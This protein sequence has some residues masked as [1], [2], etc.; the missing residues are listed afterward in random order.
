M[1]SILLILSTILTPISTNHSAPSGP[2]TINWPS[3][4]GSNACGIAE[5]VRTP[6]AWNV[7][8]K[9][10]VLWKTAIAGLGHSGPIVWENRVFVTS[11][12]SMDKKAKLKVGLYGD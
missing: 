8:K 1:H 10:N 6:S 4:R 5:G 9:Q 2:K 11:A 7:E 3:F 12:V